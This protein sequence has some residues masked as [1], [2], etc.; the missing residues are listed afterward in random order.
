MSLWNEQILLLKEKLLT[1]TFSSPSQ[2]VPGVANA[3]PIIS[4]GGYL[5]ST[6]GSHHSP[7]LEK[8]RAETSVILF[9]LGE[10]FGKHR[11]QLGSTLPA[12]RI[13]GHVYTFLMP[14]SPERAKLLAKVEIGTS[15]GILL[16]SQCYM[17]LL[18]AITAWECCPTVW[19]EIPRLSD[20]VC[21]DRNHV[22]DGIDVETGTQQSADENDEP[23]KH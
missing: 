18:M 22:F 21:G 16:D 17:L 23:L 4:P 20:L 1:R 3:S 8:D 19:P 14:D 13:I 12:M 2:T 9:R 6:L 11:A 5:T 7:I 15:G 10:I